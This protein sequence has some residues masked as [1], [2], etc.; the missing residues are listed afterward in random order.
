MKTTIL[1]A[2]S[3]FFILGFMA[4]SDTKDCRCTINSD[5]NQTVVTVSDWDGDCSDIDANDIEGF[6][7]QNPCSEQ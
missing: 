5:N 7:P 4:C 1:S 6:D 2:I 3:L